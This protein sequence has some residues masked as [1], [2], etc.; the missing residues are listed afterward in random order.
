[1]LLMMR[2]DGVVTQNLFAL[3]GYE[4]G[5]NNSNGGNEVVQLWGSVLDM[6]GPTNCNRPYFLAE[7]L[8]NTA[9]GG[10]LLATT[11]TGNNP[12]WNVNSTN[13]WGIKVNGAHYIQSFAFANGTENSL[14]VFNLSRTTALPVTFTGPNAPTGLV[15]VGLLTSA[16]LT[17]NNEKSNT[18]Q[19]QNSTIQ[20]FNA[21]GLTTLPPFS[22]TVVPLV[23]ERRSWRI[24]TFCN[25]NGYFGNADDADHRA[26]GDAEGGCHSCQWI[27]TDG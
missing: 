17:D 22:M 2:D 9:I 23:I 12:T 7:Q 19:I 20:N 15:Q 5:F 13:G 14:V 16:N 4:G 26:D 21:F 10:N 1:M 18:V 27:D 6:G 8:A 25:D 24:A 11:Q 3:P